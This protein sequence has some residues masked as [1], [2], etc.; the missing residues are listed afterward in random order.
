M[1]LL[2]PIHNAK[3]QSTNKTQSVR[4][5]TAVPTG[6]Q[7]SEAQPRNITEPHIRRP[8]VQKTGDWEI[9]PEQASSPYS[10]LGSLSPRKERGPAAR[11][12]GGGRHKDRPQT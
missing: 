11:L 8:R 2:Y 6:K 10:Y 5:R 12:G 1:L 3:T 9:L 7:A 4:R